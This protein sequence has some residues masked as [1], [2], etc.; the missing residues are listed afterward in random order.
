MEI[1]DGQ[2]HDPSTW[3]DWEGV[4][5]ETR[6]K[7]LT[8]TLFASIDAV[9]VDGAVLMA[10]APWAESVAIAH[11][12]R[13][14]S[15]PRVNPFPVVAGADGAATS[16]RASSD[17][18]DVEAPDIEEQIAA[19]FA[20]PG[21]AGI[22]FAIGFWPD[23]VERWNA[24]AFDRAVAACATQG[25]PIFMFVS[26]HLEIVAPVAQAHP[27]LTLIVDHLGLRQPPLEPVDNPPWARVSELI[28]LA[29]FPNIAV[30][31]CGATSLSTQPYPYAD[32]W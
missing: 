6:L 20:R 21:I 8:E 29:R 24:G 28:E 19:T 14:V 18:L 2:L 5:T 11:P 25:I 27:D 15:V 32:S 3:L 22:R 12:D 17:E 4:P 30:K 23:V 31:L 1:I 10:S 26:G 7:V 9:G 16:F 13:F